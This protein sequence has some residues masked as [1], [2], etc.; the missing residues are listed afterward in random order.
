MSRPTVWSAWRRAIAAGAFAPLVLLGAATGVARAGGTVCESEIYSWSG[1]ADLGAG[2]EVVATGVSIPV[3][4]GTDIIAVGASADGVSSDGMARALGVMVGDRAVMS[5]AVLIGGEISLHYT[6][7]EPVTVAGASVVVSR[8]H[9]VESAAAVAGRL[10]GPDPSPGAVPRSLSLP[11][12]GTS[13]LGLAALGAA[14]L[15]A[16]VA[17]RRLARPV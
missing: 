1:T 2:T 12:T 8:C 15:A 14:A 10:P 16:G 17:L 7:V 13:P 11:A 4:S 9:V 3:V 5:G 6:G